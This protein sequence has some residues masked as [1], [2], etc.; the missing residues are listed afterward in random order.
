[1]GSKASG[2]SEYGGGLGSTGQAMCGSEGVLQYGPGSALGSL[3]HP[4]QH[5][6]TLLNDCHDLQPQSA[7]FIMDINL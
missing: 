7:G 3:L 6:G 5:V 1:M 2:A 4:R